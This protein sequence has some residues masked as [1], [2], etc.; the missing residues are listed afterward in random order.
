M[1]GPF[2]VLCSGNCKLRIA[3]CRLQIAGWPHAA[4]W[5]AGT[6]PGLVSFQPAPERDPHGARRPSGVRGPGLDG[7][8]A[9]RSPCRVR[10]SGMNGSRRI[11]RPENGNRGAFRRARRLAPGENRGVKSQTVAAQRLTMK[12]PPNCLKKTKPLRRLDLRRFFRPA[13]PAR[14]CRR[15]L[16]ERTQLTVGHQLM[17]RDRG[18]FGPK[19]SVEKI[20]NRPGRS[21]INVLTIRPCDANS[22]GHRP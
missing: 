18:S 4:R 17:R 19:G 6:R 13:G 9:L 2:F 10:G 12:K 7:C 1:P 21:S 15:A 11:V 22:E 14:R 3:D 8:A 20:S 16:S 5:V